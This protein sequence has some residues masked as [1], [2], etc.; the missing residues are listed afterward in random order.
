MSLFV[1]YEQEMRVYEINPSVGYDVSKCVEWLLSKKSRSHHDDVHA[2]LRKF[3][4]SVAPLDL[5]YTKHGNVKFSFSDLPSNLQ[6][7]LYQYY[8]LWSASSSPRKRRA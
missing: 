4:V 3:H 1:L 5:K 2:I 7:V 6:Y 8:R